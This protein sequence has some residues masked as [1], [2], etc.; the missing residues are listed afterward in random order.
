MRC[1]AEQCR[2]ASNNSQQRFH[3]QQMRFFFVFS[4]F[5]FFFFR[6]FVL[7]VSL[8]HILIRVHVRVLDSIVPTS[9]SASGHSRDHSS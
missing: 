9:A 7:C 6:F 2:A 8:Q 1:G 4:F 3:V 5:F